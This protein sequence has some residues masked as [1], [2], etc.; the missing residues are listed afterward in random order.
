[1]KNYDLR[2]NLTGEGRELSRAEK[3]NIHW[4]KSYWVWEQL[5]KENPTVVADYFKLKRQYAK[6]DLISKYDI[7]STVLLLSKAMGRD[8]F[9][10]FNE[11]GIPADSGKTAIKLD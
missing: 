9:G 5:R 2:G 7:H 4:G 8:L 11:I 3:N 10:W 6:P 1:M